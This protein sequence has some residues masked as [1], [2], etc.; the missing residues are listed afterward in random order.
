MCVPVYIEKINKN[1]TFCFCTNFNQ[2]LRN[3]LAISM[4]TTKPA[5]QTPLD[6]VKR[7]RDC[8]LEA[9]LRETDDQERRIGTESRCCTWIITERKR[10][11]ATTCSNITSVL[12]VFSTWLSLYTFL[13][14]FFV[15]FC[16]SFF[17]WLKS[18]RTEKKKH[19]NSPPSPKGDVSVHSSFE[20]SHFRKEIWTNH[21]VE[22]CRR[23]D[24]INKT[25]RN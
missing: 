18:A 21:C 14:L 16:C 22:G 4:I 20:Q 23:V 25:I 5:V 7:E 9:P 1:K 12:P 17:V 3:P 8:W 10:G 11:Q 2:R 15:G 6:D 19:P 24:F 13:F